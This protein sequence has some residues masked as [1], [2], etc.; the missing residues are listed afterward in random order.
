MFEQ[1]WLFR[2]IPHLF[3]SMNHLVLMIGDNG[4]MVKL[5]NL[6]YDHFGVFNHWTQF[7]FWEF[8]N[9]LIWIALQ[10]IVHFDQ[11]MMLHLM[12]FSNW[13]LNILLL[14]LFASNFFTKH[15]AFHSNAS[16]TNQASLHHQSKCSN[17][18]FKASNERNLNKNF[19]N[20]K[21]VYFAFSLNKHEY[22]SY[23]WMEIVSIGTNLQ[24][25]RRFLMIFA[26]SK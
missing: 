21:Q 10:W 18:V 16:I 22:W 12:M 4:K 11:Q 13:C 25:Q 9:I 1:I 24:L 15:D 2:S 14:S 17:Q 19:Q 8:S 23:T 5:I 3:P 20:F 7:V 6:C 26:N